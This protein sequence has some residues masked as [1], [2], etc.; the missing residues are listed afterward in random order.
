MFSKKLKPF[1]NS[2][3]NASVF[4]LNSLDNASVFGFAEKKLSNPRVSVAGGGGGGPQQTKYNIVGA[5]GANT[6]TMRWYPDRSITLS[7]V[8]FSLGTAGTGTTTI[9]VKKNGTAIGGTA[10]A[11]TSGQFKSSTQTTTDTLTTSDYLTVDVAAGASAADA[12][13]CIVYS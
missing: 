11:A 4:P 13:V 12:V 5:L 9:T 2:P 8:Y 1:V 10:P 7:Q 6:G 3:E